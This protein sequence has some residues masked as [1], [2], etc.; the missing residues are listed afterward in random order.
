MKRKYVVPEISVVEYEVEDIVTDSLL[1]S[2]TNAQNNQD[3]TE[4]DFSQIFGG[5]P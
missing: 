3:D 1:S 4:V 2:E 5:T